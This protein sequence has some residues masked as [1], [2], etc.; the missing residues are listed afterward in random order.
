MNILSYERSGDTHK[1]NIGLS[2]GRTAEVVVRLKRSGLQVDGGAV[3]GVEKSEEV[4]TFREAA[5]WL[6]RFLEQDGAPRQDVLTTF[7]PAD[8]ATVP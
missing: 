2:K 8:P 1:Y 4:S 5:D 7:R 6:S 3:T